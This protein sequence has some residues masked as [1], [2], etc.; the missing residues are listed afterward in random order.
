[1]A[2]RAYGHDQRVSTSLQQPFRH[3]DSERGKHIGQGRLSDRLTVGRIQL[4]YL[5]MSRGELYKGQEVHIAQ[6]TDAV[7]KRRRH[8]MGT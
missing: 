4:R 7:R 3:K 6:V 5:R 1:M 2:A 8:E